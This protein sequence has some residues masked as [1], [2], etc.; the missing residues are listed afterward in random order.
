MPKIDKYVHQ[1][2]KF[3]LDKTTQNPQLCNTI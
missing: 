1:I 2:N 3:V